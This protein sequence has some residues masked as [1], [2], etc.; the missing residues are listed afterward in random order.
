MR[1]RLN[2]AAFSAGERESFNRFSFAI[3]Q[4]HLLVLNQK[5][6]IISL[7]F[8]IKYCYRL[9]NVI[10][11]TKRKS[12]G[13]FAISIYNMQGFLCNKNHMAIA[14]SMKINKFNSA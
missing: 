12:S 3:I 4:Q 8:I 5:E 11:K 7:I 14:I 2:N 6:S 1:N 10:L 9:S 13:V